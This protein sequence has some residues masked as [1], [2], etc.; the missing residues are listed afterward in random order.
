MVLSILCRRCGSAELGSLDGSPLT[1][2]FKADI[3][4]EVRLL[5]TEHGGRQGPT[6]TDK[7]GCPVGIG[8]EFFD[9]RIDLSDTGSLSPGQTARVPMAFLR[10]DLVLPLLQIGSEFN[11]WDGRQV[12]SAGHCGGWFV[13]RRDQRAIDRRGPRSRH[14]SDRPIAIAGMPSDGR[15]C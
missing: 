14:R 10:P 4:A 11:L 2:P 9:M 6:P 5:S 12:A 13:L 1:V 8:A 7:F 3:L 15:A